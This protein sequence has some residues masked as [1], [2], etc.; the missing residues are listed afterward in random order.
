MQRVER[1]VYRMAGVTDKVHPQLEGMQ[2]ELILERVN[3]SEKYDRIARRNY[4]LSD[5]Q[6]G[7]CSLDL[8][9]LAG[10]V[11]VPTSSAKL[12]EA[13]GGTHHLPLFLIVA[14]GVGVAALC[15][16]LLLP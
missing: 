7:S 2:P 11:D 14:V 4:G 10:A 16:F 13:L 9:V 6:A 3:E 15:R 5:N 12:L 8:H 1:H